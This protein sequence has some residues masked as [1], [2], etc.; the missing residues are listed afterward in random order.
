MSVEELT[1]LVAAVLSLLFSYVPGF[2]TK[3]QAL[4]AQEKQGVMLLLLALSVGVIVALSC[5]PVADQ[6]GFAFP[7]DTSGFVAAIK[8][9]GLA[10]IAN[11]TTYSITKHLPK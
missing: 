1:A 9:F 7:C 6:L 5:S 3:W 2:K 8:L 10:A 4:A 11:Q